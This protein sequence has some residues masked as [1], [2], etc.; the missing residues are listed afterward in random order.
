MLSF[1]FQI[2]IVLLVAGFLAWL[3]GKL[4]FIAPPLNQIV[5]GII[6]FVALVFLLYATYAFFVGGPVPAL[7]HVGRR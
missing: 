6:L 4:P 5:Q 7:G 2:V 1:L 3:V